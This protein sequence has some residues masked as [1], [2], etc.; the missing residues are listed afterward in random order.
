MVADK[1]ENI[2]ARCGISFEILSKEMQ[3]KLETL[4]CVAM[5]LDSRDA[6]VGRF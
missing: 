1:Y 3:Q 5:T 4:V 6:S 2:M